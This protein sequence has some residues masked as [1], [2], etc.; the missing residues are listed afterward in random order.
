MKSKIEQLDEFAGLAMQAMIS[1]L[2]M[3]DTNGDFGK[4][5]KPEEL[6]V[7]KEHIALSAYEYAEWMLVARKYAVEWVNNQGLETQ[8]SN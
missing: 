4:E 1:K 5:I 6:A 7:I 3:Y 2:P 8:H